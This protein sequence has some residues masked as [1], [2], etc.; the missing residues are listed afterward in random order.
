MA[1]GT[2]SRSDFFRLAQRGTTVS[3]EVQAGVTTFMVMSYILFVNPSILGAVPDST[4][5]RLGFGA[6]LSVTALAAGVLTILM[7]LVSNY[8]FA[9]AAGLGLNA[10][11]A[12]QLV[13]TLGL[14]WPEAM[15]VVVLEGAIIAVL[16]LTRFR[17]AVMSAIP[18]S[19]KRAIGV[20]IGLFIALIGF[21]QAGFVVR[22]PEGGTVLTLGP[23]SG[24]PIAVSV[25]GLVLGSVLLARRVKGALLVTILASTALAM[26]LNAVYGGEQ[27]ANGIARL[28]ASL[29]S[30]P[31]FSLLGRFDVV[32]VFAKLGLITALL[33]IF[34][35][36]LSDFFDTMGT[37]LGLGEQAGFVQQ[38]GTLPRSNRVLFVDS[39]GALFGG[40]TSSSSNTTY[41]EA[42]SGIAEGARTGLASVITGVLFLLATFLSP[43]AGVVPAQATAPALIL[44]GFL[45][46]GIVREIDWSVLDEAIPAF[47]IMLV[48][49][50]TYSI[51]NGIG[52]GFLLF[53]AIK[54]LTG[55]GAQVHPMMWLAS[56]G[57]LVYF[58]LPTIEKLI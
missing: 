51:T 42:A 12:F 39:L 9:L 36:L 7:G 47:A 14:T 17:V 20:G 35:I 45:M 44:V 33:T 32:G 30:W 2:S 43:L 29:V 18:L 55:R 1:T 56:L 16:V 24:V 8:P 49:P 41:I 23:T 5:A 4:G 31:D 52:A 22:G 34:A 40:V 13:G 37:M 27:F 6:V 50:F 48:M 54:L 15:G 19:L 46:I 11:V 26:V 21:V 3:R 38:D 10:V 25:F 57:F 53:A 58:L 28:P